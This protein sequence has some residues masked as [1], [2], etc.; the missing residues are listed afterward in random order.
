MDKGWM[1]LDEEPT[2]FSPPHWVS[3]NA[4]GISDRR[5][6]VV[7]QLAKMRPELMSII[8]R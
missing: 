5:S 7:V 6:N 8:R 4:I 2:F 3:R 1:E